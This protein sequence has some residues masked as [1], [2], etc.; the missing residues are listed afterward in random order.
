ML[1]RSA[2]APRKKNAPRPAEKSAP[3]YLKWLRG[4]P[5][6]VSRIRQT[7]AHCGG[8]PV[9]AHVDHGGDKGM[10]TK[11]SDKFAL[12]LCSYCHDRQHRIGW[13]SFEK[14]YGFSGISIAEAYWLEWLKNTPMGRAWEK[15]D[16]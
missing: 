12:P 15:R 5:C 4:R 13:E 8:K 16:A 6:L 2:F 11:V 9:A 3:G 7:L 1:S 10:G 14:L